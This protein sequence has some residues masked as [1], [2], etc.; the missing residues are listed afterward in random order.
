MTDHEKLVDI[1]RRKPGLRAGQ[2]APEIG[3]TR[4]HVNSLLY[5]SLASKVWQDSNYRWWLADDAQ[6]RKG[7]PERTSAT[8][9]QDSRHGRLCRYY[10]D[11]LSREELGEVSVFASGKHG[12]DYIELDTLPL[13]GDQ[14][15]TGLARHMHDLKQRSRPRASSVALYLGYPVRLRWQHAQSGWMGFF[16]EPVF[17]FIFDDSKLDT[18]DAPDIDPIPSLNPAVVKRLS[19]TDGALGGLYETIALAEELGFSGEHGQLPDFEDVV[20]RLISIRPQW[21]WLEQIDPYNLSREPALCDASKRGIYNRAVLL[22]TERPRYTRGLETEL[23]ELSRLPVSKLKGTA[24]GDWLSDVPPHK[25]HPEPDSLLEVVALN[26]EQRQAVQQGLSNPL[27][28]ITGPPGTGK[29]Q[30]VTA[31]LAN[32][33][34]HNQTVLMASKN[35]KAVDVVVERTNGLGSRPLLLRV[36]KDEHHDA[37]SMYLSELLAGQVSADDR[38]EFERRLAGLRSLGEQQAALDTELDQVTQARNLT[39]RLA[40][41]V[42]YLRAELGHEVFAAI[43]HRD[44]SAFQTQHEALEQALRRASPKQAGRLTELFWFCLARR[45][46]AVLAQAAQRLEECV[47][48]HVGSPD[49]PPEWPHRAQWFDYCNKLLQRADQIQAVRAYFDAMRQLQSLRTPEKIAAERGDISD[50]LLKESQALWRLWLKLQPDRL[51]PKQRKAIAD[52]HSTLKLV[53]EARSSDSPTRSR[54][55]AQ[56]Y[57]LLPEVSSA[58]PCWAVTSLSARN[59]VPFTP[60]LFDLLVIDEASQCDIA[61]A[62]PLLFRAKRAVI[63]GDP[64]QL[65]HI[66]ALTAVQDQQLR[67]MHLNWPDSESWSYPVNS[68]FDRA[69]GLAS[70]GDMLALR[71]HHRSHADIIEFSNDN[72]YTQSLRIATRYER[73]NRPAPPQTAVRWI[74]VSGQ[75]RQPPQGSAV[76]EVEVQAVVEELRSLVVERD[77]H[78]T[79]GI[80]TPF[81]AQADRLRAA[82]FGDE[83][84]SEQLLNAEL[85][86]DTVHA[87]QGDERDVIFFSP[88]VSSG[89]TDGALRFLSGNG[90]LFNVAIT[91]ARSSL[92]AVG[93]LRFAMTSDI[94]YL[95]AFARHCQNLASA[96]LDS[97][98]ARADFGPEYPQVQRPDMVSDWERLMYRALYAE[99]MRPVPQFAV[100]QYNLDLA[101]FSGTR[102]LDVEIDGEQHRDWNGE[103]CRRDQMR[104]QRLIELGW[105]V[106]RFWVCQVRD[107][108]HGCVARVADWAGGK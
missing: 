98:Q 54:I 37:L 63:I 26:P 30:V 62:L 66:S 19:T 25:S 24:L 85:L 7:P 39:E 15:V 28:V 64:M 78:G 87:F 50:D 76:N 40:E 56:Y 10:L 60:A 75:V 83:Q 13:L 80:V 103:L 1:L 68:L 21:D 74:H 42:H 91:R 71:D 99:G 6:A 3:C 101:L 45:R 108:L 52:F 70:S 29:S 79:I 61:S 93:D 90:N 105:D 107:D 53:I 55:W 20:M 94:S 100:D 44:M 41:E 97:Q 88:V 72:F 65:R 69:Q 96:E 11:C 35:N 22:A 106:M 51:S 84:L 16:V 48:P 9:P 33:A 18:G 67:E 31:L 92:I 8:L 5:G 17:L 36:G 102:K 77:Y 86:V 23:A 57:R 89:V 12:L 43:R 32:A 46:M 104:N 38:S 49:Q 27:T 73:L 4:Q 34:M 47:Q 2:I 59:R 81:R 58:L 82:V 14:V 95:A